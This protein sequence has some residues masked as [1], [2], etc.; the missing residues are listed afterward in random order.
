MDGLS[1]EYHLTFRVHRSG[2][3]LQRSAFYKLVVPFQEA[4]NVEFIF[5][6]H[7]LGPFKMV[8]GRFTAIDTRA[9]AAPDAGSTRAF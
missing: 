9:A 2:K 5:E 4:A 3:T 6:K 7:D 8:H 1:N